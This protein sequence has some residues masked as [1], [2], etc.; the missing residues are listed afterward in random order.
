MYSPISNI[1]LAQPIAEYFEPDLVQRHPLGTV[2]QGVSSYW[3]MGEF[4]Y[5]KAGAAIATVGRLSQPDQNMVFTDVPSTANMGRPV[6]VN[7]YPMAIDEFGWFQCAGN[8]IF[9]AGAS[10]AAD[11]AFGIHTGAGQVGTL[12]VGKQILGAR[13]RLAS[14]ATVVKTNCIVTNGSGVVVCGNVDGWF[15]GVTLSGTGIPASSEIIAIN[16]SRR[17]VVMSELATAGGTVT[18]TGT[19]T[20]FIVAQCYRP[21]TQGAIT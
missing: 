8:M 5:G 10:V 4:V 18:V 1:F 21:F 15:H 17:E 19:Y 13:N 16:P 9:S 20:G 2:V 7:I 12:A 3:G 11:T 6:F 14:T